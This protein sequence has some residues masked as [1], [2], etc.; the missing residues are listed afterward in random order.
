MEGMIVGSLFH[1]LMPSALG[2]FGIVW[3]ET[4]KG[5]KVYS[6]LLPDDQNSV[7]NLARSAF[8]HSSHHTC[9]SITELG[10]RIQ[11]FLGGEA[12]DFGLDVIALEKCSEFQRRV[13]LA[14]HKI[15]RGWVSTYGR[16]AGSAEVLGGARAVGG[17]LARNPF[18]IIIPCHRVIRSDGELGGFGGGLRM[19]QTLLELEGIEFSRSR[20][21]PANRIQY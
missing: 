14:V 21:V 19:K 17:A 13:L 5:W 1:V 12:V 8:A 18:P 3:Q 2:T 10:E 20:R 16:I 9:P 11:S 7:G 4:E 6:V 15:P